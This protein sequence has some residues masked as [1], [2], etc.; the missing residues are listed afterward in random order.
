MSSLWLLP[1]SRFLSFSGSLRSFGTFF[2]VADSL[3]GEINQTHVRCHKDLPSVIESMKLPRAYAP[4]ILHF[5]GG[6]RRSTPLRSSSFGGSTARIPPRPD[7]RGLLRR[8]IK[9]PAAPRRLKLPERLA[10]NSSVHFPLTHAPRQSRCLGNVGGGFNSSAFYEVSSIT[11][12]KIVKEKLFHAQLGSKR[13]LNAIVARGKSSQI[14][15]VS[16]TQ[17]CPEMEVRPRHHLSF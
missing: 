4:G 16:G 10:L 7:G 13:R 3:I 12:E 1:K 9:K 17:D 8:R 14:L 6:I 5:F 15:A 2:D 11:R